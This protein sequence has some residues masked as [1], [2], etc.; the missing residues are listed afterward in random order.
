MQNIKI[1]LKRI[2]LSKENIEIYLFLLQNGS[3]T[4]YEISRYTK[5]SRTSVYRN[6][7]QLKQEDLIAKVG[8]S[9]IKYECREIKVLKEKIKN[10]KSKSKSLNKLFNEAEQSLQN[11]PIRQ[12]FHSKVVEY[13]GVEEVKNLIWNTLNAKEETIGYGKVLISKYFGEEFINEWYDKFCTKGLFDRQILNEENLKDIR[14]KRSEASSMGYEE[15]FK[16]RFI[17]KDIFQIQ[18][19]VF[20]YNNVYAVLQKQG[21]DMFGFEIYNRKIAEQEKEFFELLW[22][23][24]E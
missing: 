22:K 2:G 17:S 3:S 7:E 6:C 11:F 9:P 24:V 14:R 16:I 5:V 4:V 13:S 12:N 8:S 23:R 21:D 1:F 10:M 19:E 15:H 20:V 18:Q